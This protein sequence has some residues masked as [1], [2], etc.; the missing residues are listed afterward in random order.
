MTA[1]EAMLLAGAWKARCDRAERQRDALQELV[2]RSYRDGYNA[3]WLRGKNGKPL[4][5]QPGR[6]RPRHHERAMQS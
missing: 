6:G 1:H 2:T 3:G 5:R 4:E